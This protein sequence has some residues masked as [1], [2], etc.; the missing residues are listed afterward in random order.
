LH[1]STTQRFP[2]AQSVW[3]VQDVLHAP[4]TQRYALQGCSTLPAGVKVTAAV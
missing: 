4:S 2:V 1:V 3:A